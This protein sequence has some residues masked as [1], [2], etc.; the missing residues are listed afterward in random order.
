MI[1]KC[2]SWKKLTQTFNKIKA[3]LKW[4]R[5]PYLVEVGDD[6]VEEAETLHA[7]VV[8][9]RLGVEVGKARDGGEHDAHRVV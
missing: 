6:L 9:L 4:Q 8:H 2:V 5:A 7:L 3:F 1:L